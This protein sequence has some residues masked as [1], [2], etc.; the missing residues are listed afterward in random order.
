MNS[1]KINHPPHYT[2]REHECIDEMVAVFG[3]DSV[4]SFCKCNAWKYR[5]RAGN[6]GNAEDD[7]KKSDW[8]ISKLIELEETRNET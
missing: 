6:K 5:Y 1:E 8:Y 3:V 4:I 2:C 7:L